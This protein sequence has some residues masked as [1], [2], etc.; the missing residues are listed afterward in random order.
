MAAAYPALGLPQGARRS[1]IRS[2]YRRLVLKV[3][4]DRRGASDDGAAFRRLKAAYDC[5]VKHT[6]FDEELDELDEQ[7][8]AEERE[9]VE[10]ETK[11]FERELRENALADRKTQRARRQAEEATDAKDEARRRRREADDDTR[12]LQRA[13]DDYVRS[14][15]RWGIHTSY[16]AEHKHRVN[17]VRD[18]AQ[19]HGPPAAVMLRWP[20]GATEL[21]VRR[22]GTVSAWNPRGSPVWKSDNKTAVIEA[23][24]GPY[25]A[26]L[27]LSLIHI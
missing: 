2:A 4:P 5:L 11:R 15:L 10:L 23:R 24:V 27:W 22:P 14:R 3:H 9:L 18:D 7:I 6:Q 21:C 26:P 19:S 13:S 16:D 25:G 1:E 12:W 17:L 20:N 8:E